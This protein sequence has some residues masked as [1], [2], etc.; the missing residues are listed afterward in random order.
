MNWQS[1]MMVAALAKG[2]LDFMACKDP[3]DFAYWVSISDPFNAPG[4]TR[5]AR[6]Y[7]AT[8]RFRGNNNQDTSEE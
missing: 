1:A 7:A 8:M 5:G 2:D 6:D 3:A 4:I